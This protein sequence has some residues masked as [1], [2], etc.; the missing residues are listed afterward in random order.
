MQMTLC[1]TRWRVLQEEEQKL[2]FTRFVV[3]GEDQ[4]KSIG[5][6]SR[7]FRVIC[8]VNIAIIKFINQQLGKAVTVVIR[9]YHNP[10]FLLVTEVDL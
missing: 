3:I 2:R 10:V 6:L 4:P 8:K 5:L 7:N 1:C 9:L